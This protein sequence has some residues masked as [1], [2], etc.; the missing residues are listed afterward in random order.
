[1]SPVAAPSW[2]SRAVPAG[3]WTEALTQLL[4]NA[5]EENQSGELGA[6]ERADLALREILILASRAAETPRRAPRQRAPDHSTRI[7]G[8]AARYLTDNLAQPL[9]V[10]AV[11]RYHSLSAAHFSVIFKRHH[12]KNPRAFLHAA[13]I[14]RAQALLAEG[15]LRIKE[16]AATCGYAD[17]AHFCRRFKAA[18]GKTPKAFR[19]SAPT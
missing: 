2:S 9:S 15:R 3:A 11:A 14:A 18:T 1:A 16:I 12:G 13:R 10:Q 5:F 8:S 4:L 7:A 19:A 6:H 17:A